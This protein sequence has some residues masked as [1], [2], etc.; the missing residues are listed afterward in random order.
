MP[1]HNTTRCGLRTN[2]IFEILI[3]SGIP[4]H[5]PTQTVVDC[6]QIVSLKS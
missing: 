3:N 2:C 6:A 5:E 4:Y 1:K